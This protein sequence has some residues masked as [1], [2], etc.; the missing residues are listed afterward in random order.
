MFKK[1]PYLYTY[2]YTDVYWFQNKLISTERVKK[3][4]QPF[5]KHSHLY[6]QNKPGE[7]HE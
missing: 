5:C 3:P 4:T 1:K 2:P 6:Y 7:Y